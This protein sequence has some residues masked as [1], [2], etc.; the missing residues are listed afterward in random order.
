[1]PLPPNIPLPRPL[2]RTTKHPHRPIPKRERKLISILKHRL[3]TILPL[4]PSA[5]LNIT[6]A[7]S[8]KVKE[9]LTDLPRVLE[10]RYA[11]V[12]RTKSVDAVL[13]V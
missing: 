12:V 9:H 4:R 11:A 1:M 6:A 10:G 3:P 7:P 5:I 2:S 8:T 13:I